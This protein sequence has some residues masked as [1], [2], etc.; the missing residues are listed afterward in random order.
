MRACFFGIL[1]LICSHSWAIPHPS[2]GAPTAAA[3][4]LKPYSAVPTGHHNVEYLKSTLVG[5]EKIRWVLVKDIASGRT[6]WTPKQNLLTPLH[7]STKARLLAGSPVYREKKDRAPDTALSPKTET[8]VD[9]LDIQNEW[10][11]VSMNLQTGVTV[12]AWVP[13]AQLYTVDR[14]AGYFFARCDQPLRK[15]GAIKSPTLGKVA[16]GQRLRPIGALGDWVHVG[17]NSAKGY[18]SGYL[19]SNQIISRVDISMK[20]KTDKGFEK[21]RHT[22]IGEKIYA[23]YVNPLWLGTAV[24]PVPLFQEPIASAPVIGYAKPWGHLLQ[25]D[26]IEQDWAA[27]KLPGGLVWWQIPDERGELMQ[28]TKLALNS[29]KQIKENPL[30]K[31]IKTASA[32]GLY[33]TTDGVY[34]A[35]I[36]GFQGYNPAFTYAKDGTLFVEDQVSFDNGEHFTPYVFWE[37]LLKTLRENN[38]GVKNVVKITDIETIN[39]TSQQVILE[40]DIGSARKVKMYTADRGQTWTLLRL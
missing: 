33:R 14:D 15:T 10:V 35:P 11:M 19:P 8:S 1:L 18:V 3:I 27:S 16:S 22:M 20:V 9:L 5:Q 2:V 24:H 30:F 12:T 26:S 21:P 32:R 34:W 38:R 40:L 29:I 28:L 23:I 25:Q 31:H 39:N 4:F 17:Y 7:F 13:I 36:R 6:G 37:N